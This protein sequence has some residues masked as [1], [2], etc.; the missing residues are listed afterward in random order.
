MAAAHLR[1]IA[2]QH[3]TNSSTPGVIKDEWLSYLI[4][5]IDN[6]MLLNV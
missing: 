6:G 5:Q 2:I 4:R 1:G 3:M